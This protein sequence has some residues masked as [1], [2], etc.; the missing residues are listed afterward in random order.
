MDKENKIKLWNNIFLNIMK[1]L[2]KIKTIKET[3]FS[4]NINKTNKFNY[5]IKNKINI[6]N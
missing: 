3:F 5:L 1:I 2:N 6:Q 4:N